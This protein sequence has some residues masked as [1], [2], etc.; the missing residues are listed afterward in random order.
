MAFKEWA[1]VC[2]ALVDGRQSLILRKGGIDED[3]GEFRP[4][5]PSFWLYPTHLH[6]SQQGLRDSSVP[7]QWIDAPPGMLAL[8]GLVVVECVSWVDRE[9]TLDSLADLHVWTA[10]TVLKR[11]HYRRPGLWV[12]GV[13][14]YRADP[15]PK[16][17]MT[18][19]QAGCRSWVPLEEPIWTEDLSPVIEESDLDTRMSRIRSLAERGSR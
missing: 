2:E 8:P 12:L 1:G 6:E 19:E 7:L 10:E 18:P 3:H 17:V 16:I 11:F 9:E 15:A 14:A 4:E 13:R 5:Y